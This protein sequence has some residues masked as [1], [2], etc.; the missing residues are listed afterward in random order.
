MNFSIIQV[1]Q[2]HKEVLDNLMQFYIYDFSEFLAFD[3]E[4]NGQYSPYPLDD[5][6]EEGNHQFAYV[7]KREE[8]YIGFVLVRLIEDLEIRH[9]SITEFFI[10]KKYRREG[11]G[12][13][14]ATDL[15]NRHKGPWEVH[16]IESNKG[17]QIFWKRVIN[18]YT[19]GQFEE[20]VENG[21][22]IQTFIS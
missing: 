19:K 1:N 9:Y 13:A 6:F 5:Y 7:I 15:F 20:R 10:L 22:T 8:K 14:V 16:Q 11:M 12:M 4:E 18:E 21:K 17:A 2:K 3:V